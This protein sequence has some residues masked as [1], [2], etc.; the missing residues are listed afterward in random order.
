M[1]EEDRRRK[2]SEAYET[3]HLALQAILYDEDPA[4]FGRSVG[5]PENEYAAEASHLIALLRGHTRVEDVG[6]VLFDV[7]K[8][9][10][11]SLTARV[12]EAWRQFNELT[13]G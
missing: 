2:L 7:F 8:Q 3:L 11:P 6:R 4:G 1:N 5:A 9:N 12:Y 10:T 13:L